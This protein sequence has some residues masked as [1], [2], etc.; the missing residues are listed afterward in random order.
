MSD[1]AI[2]KHLINLEKH[3]SASNPI[4]QRASQV[5]QQLDQ[6]E[7]ELGLLDADETTARK[8]SWWPIIS[9]IGGFSPATFRVRL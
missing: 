2:S 5:F 8:T 3:F 4:L 6:L 9:L 1:K 7:F